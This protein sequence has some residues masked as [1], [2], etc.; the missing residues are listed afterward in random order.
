MA[1]ADRR[2]ASIPVQVNKN[3]TGSKDS[4]VAPKTI[5]MIYVVLDGN[6]NTRENIGD[7]EGLKCEHP[8]IIR[9]LSQESN[10]PESDRCDVKELERKSS[11]VR[12]SSIIRRKLSRD[13]SRKGDRP[14]VRNYG[15]NLEDYK[16]IEERV[17]SEK[18]VVNAIEALQERWRM[19]IYM[20]DDCMDLVKEKKERDMYNKKIRRQEEI[21]IIMFFAA[22][23]CFPISLVILFWLCKR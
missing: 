8:R 12:K 16:K 15:N 11:L 20:Y 1:D 17:L 6:S 5:D 23:V 3:A 4:Q 2:L 10:C 19:L 14:E 7:K 21:V 22:V 13:G 9:G 18:A